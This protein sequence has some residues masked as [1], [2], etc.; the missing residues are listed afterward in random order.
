MWPLHAIYLCM[1]VW[2]GGKQEFTFFKIKM[3]SQKYHQSCTKL[4]YLTNCVFPYT[5]EH[6]ISITKRSANLIGEKTASHITLICTYLITCE[7]E[8]LFKCYLALHCFSTNCLCIFYIHCSIWVVFS[9][10]CLDI[11]YI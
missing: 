8:Y 7:V 3:K 9:Y 2:W 11:F 5:H 1:C 4:A 10:R 6:L